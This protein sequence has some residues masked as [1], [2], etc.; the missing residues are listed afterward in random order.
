MKK[1]EFKN[2]IF[3]IDII[4]MSIDEIQ[5]RPAVFELVEKVNLPALRII[6]DNFEEVFK[7]MGGK[8]KL[9]NE[10]THEYEICADY[11][12]AH[13]IINELYNS[14]KTTDKVKYHYTAR[15]DYGRRFAPKSLQGTAREIRHAIAK[16]IY[17]DLDFKNAHP[18]IQERKCM[19]MDFKHEPLSHYIA[20][21][22]EVLKERIGKEM[23]I[24]VWENPEKTKGH[25]DTII[26]KKEDVKQGFLTLLNGGSN[27]FQ[28]DE[29]ANLFEQRQKEF[30]KEFCNYRKYPD[31][32]KYVMRSKNK[33]YNAEGSALNHY[34]CD[35]EDKLL[36]HVENCL[37]DRDIQY[38]TLCFDGLQIYKDSINDVQQVL[39]DIEQS[40]HTSF[41]YPFKLSVKPMDEDVKLDG[42]TEKP[43]LKVSDVD[44]ALY[45]LDKLKDDIKYHTKLNQM[46]KWNSNVALWRPMKIENM[47]S[48]IPDLLVPHINTSPDPEQIQKEMS[49]IHSS[50]KQKSILYQ[51]KNRIEMRDDDDFIQK[52]FDVKKG[53]IPIKDNKTIDMRT[54]EVR[55]RI[56][57]DYFT[58]TTDRT[59]KPN[60]NQAKVIE[61]YESILTKHL[62]SKDEEPVITKIKP[63]REYRECFEQ[64]I[65]YS[66]TGENNLKKFV[67]LIGNGD[68]GKSVFIELHQEVFN[69]FSTQGNK[70]TFISQKSQSNHD[71]EIMGLINSRFV[72]LTELKKKEAFN[73]ELIKAI[74]GGDTQKVRGCGQKDTIEVL[75]SCVLWIATNELAKF[76][77]EQFKNR[78][79]CIYFAN[80]FDKNPKYVEELKEMY[81]DFF[82][83]LCLSA[84]KY[85]ENGRSITF[86]PEI[87][88]Y[89]NKMKNSQNSFLNWMEKQDIFEINEEG[90]E[91]DRDFI[92][93]DYY[94][95]CRSSE[96]SKIADFYIQFEKHLNVEPSRKPNNGFRYYKNICRL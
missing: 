72:S 86:C 43:D 2:K 8:M 36:Q 47:I 88:D 85:Y 35:V 83:H 65:A 17:I 13:T 3:I 68:N 33:T 67:N 41:N 84:Q 39:A 93:E 18:C 71:A 12:Q 22:D 34:F 52:N 25:Y 11:S 55:P 62:V 42:L 92:R 58:K 59:F 19:E 53:L 21:R 94:Q 79:L 5:S 81:D 26:A 37:Q 38:G 27:R 15:V 48:F 78:L 76:E 64:V 44:Y 31:H 56:R 46:Y 82:T 7:R 57:E 24:K 73:E 30:V 61:Y 60:Y 23:K 74:S 40:L 96:V 95:F 14:K 80:K 4:K 51:L 70:R 9:F 1:K 63:S 66:M 16:D 54:C 89:T 90:E 49:Q 77:N 91:M 20:N 10:K 75:F 50:S 87:D 45:I 32:N 69:G 29:F 28:N 6:R